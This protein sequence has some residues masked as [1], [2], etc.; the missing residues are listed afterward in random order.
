MNGT[1]DDS[2]PYLRDK[3]SVLTFG[4]KNCPTNGCIHFLPM[5]S[6]YLN[7]FH[8]KD[9]QITEYKLHQRAWFIHKN[10]HMYTKKPLAIFFNMTQFTYI[11]K[12]NYPYSKYHSE[13][14]VYV[15]K[16][17]K[18]GENTITKSIY[19]HDVTSLKNRLNSTRK[20]R[21]LYLL[22]GICILCL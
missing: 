22:K 15:L 2:E 11:H 20:T 16:W 8:Y 18:D 19:K 1:L 17:R 6:K 14:R 3:N 5:Y 12:Q 9:T 13:P 10:I 21:I 4:L 7:I